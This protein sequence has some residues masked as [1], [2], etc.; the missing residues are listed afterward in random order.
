MKLKN[1]APIVL[2]IAVLMLNACSFSAEP[3]PTATSAPTSTPAATSTKTPTP[4]KTPP[5]T[6]TPNL[7]ATRRSEEWNA[8]IQRYFDEGYIDTTKG[9]FKKLD[10]FSEA[11]AQLNWYTT[12]PLETAIEDF[13]FSGHFEWSSASKTPNPSGCGLVYAMQ[14]EGRDGYKDYSV[15]LDRAQILYLRTEF[16]HGFRVGKTRGTTTVKFD[17]PLEADFTLIVYDHYSY[18][19]LNGEVIGEYTLPQSDLIEGALGISILSGTN[20]DYGTRCEITN[21]HLWTPIK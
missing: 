19:I 14:G 10:D 1:K 5:P 21:A 2:I 16:G 4:T 17:D 15:F 6:I 7:T 3:T 11:W 13:V 20:K 9:K 12:W 8:E 18:V